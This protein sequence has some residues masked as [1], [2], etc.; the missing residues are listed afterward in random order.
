MV[1]IEQGCIDVWIDEI[2]PCLKDTQTG[3][4]K[5]T[6]V[7]KIESRAYLKKFRKGNGWH[8][9]WSEIPKDVEVYALAL[10]DD[11]SIQGLV[12]IRNDKDS[13]AAYLHWACTA[14]HNNKHENGSQKYVGVGGHLFAIA[15]DKSIEWGYEGAVHGFAA[16]ADLLRHYINVFHAEYLGMLHQYQF[17]IDEEQAKELL[18]V[19]HYEWNET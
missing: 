14:P 17:F 16:N 15:A 6:V 4:I 1:L 11:N 2:V 10:K 5:E 13:C 12:G 7:F 8:I 18:E 19:Y 9:N 3:E